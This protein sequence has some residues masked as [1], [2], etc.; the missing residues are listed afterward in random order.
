MPAAGTIA[1]GFEQHVLC[2][3]LGSLLAWALGLL[4]YMLFLLWKDYVSL[5]ASAF[6]LSQ[7]LHTPRSALVLWAQRLRDPDGPPLYKRL[8][9]TVTSP[10][11]ILG[12]LT[13]IPSLVQLSLLL[14]LDLIDDVT[15][16]IT[17]AYAL[18]GFTLVLGV[19]VCVF[20][21]HLL[22]YD[23]CGAQRNG[24]ERSEAARGR[25]LTPPSEGHKQT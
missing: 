5:I 19:L 6:L 24:R 20:D 3:V 16:L 15:P 14:A 23:R 10:L 7:A 1:A 12:K 13:S 21:R 4:G 18:A 9:G 17:I 2:H 25:T 11:S 22:A 8:L